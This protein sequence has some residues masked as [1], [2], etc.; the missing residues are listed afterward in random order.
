MTRK[1]KAVDT[2]MG[3][4]AVKEEEGITDILYDLTKN[5]F[6]IYCRGKLI[7]TVRAN[8]YLIEWETTTEGEKK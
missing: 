6:E 2:S 1:I 4:F 5:I 7:F 3:M 8:E